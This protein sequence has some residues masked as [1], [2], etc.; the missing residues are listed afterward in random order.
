V[1]R[2]GE[3]GIRSVSL[4]ACGVKPWKRSSR[5]HVCDAP[6]SGSRTGLALV[7]TGLVLVL[8]GLIPVLTSIDPIERLRRKLRYRTLRAYE[9]VRHHDRPATLASLSL[10]S[11]DASLNTLHT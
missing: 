9:R 2:G 1:A 3:D 10:G 6:P 4:A 5:E 8:T 7:V 11:L